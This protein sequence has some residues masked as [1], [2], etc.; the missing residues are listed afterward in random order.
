MARTEDE[1]SQNIKVELVL[2][3]VFN[4]VVFYL[5]YDIARESESLQTGKVAL[6]FIALAF[7]LCFFALRRWQEM[8]TLLQQAHV[9]SIIDTLTAVYN[10]TYM[11]QIIEIEVERA[12][13]SKT[14]LSVMLIDIDNLQKIN[15][16]YGHDLGDTIILDLS[17]ILTQVVRKVDII[18]RWEG[19]KFMILCPDTDLE[20]AQIAA[21]RVLER[22]RASSFGAAGY[23]T[24]SIGMTTVKQDDEIDAFIHRTDLAL[25]EAKK[26][27]KNRITVL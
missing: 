4:A 26:S 16:K 19:G 14:P 21:E 27:G 2:L 20:G 10:R 8:K 1:F 11:Q 22:V 12:S 23:I 17:A 25:G 5:F 3:V 15:E 13:R 9:E 24:A 7:S 6:L 18:A